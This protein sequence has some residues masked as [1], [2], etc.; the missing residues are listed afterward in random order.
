LAKVDDS[1]GLCHALPILQEMRFNG[2]GVIY[3][4][5]KLEYRTIQVASDSGGYSGAGAGQQCSGAPRVYG[6]GTGCRESKQK[7]LTR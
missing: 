3:N 1:S 7:F 4:E 6:S 5:K 2:E